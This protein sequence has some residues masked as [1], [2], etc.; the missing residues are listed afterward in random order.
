MKD[1]LHELIISVTSRCNLRCL[2]CGIPDGN[3]HDALSTAALKGLISDAVK[4]NPAS[5][6]F[7]GGEPLLREDIFE[8]ISFVNERKV[9]TCLTSNGSLINEDRAKLLAA[10]GV[11][12]VNISIEGPEEA[13]DLLRGRGNFEKAVTALENLKKHKI[14]TTIATVVCRHNYKSLAYV[15]GLARRYGVT[16]VK[17]QPF[18]GIFLKDEGTSRDFFAQEKDLKELD[19]AIEEVIKLSREYNISTNPESYLRKIPLYLCGLSGSNGKHGCSAL[20]SSCPI[21]ADGEV[22]PCWVLSAK[23]I[24]NI[25]GK[26]ISEIWNSK[27]HNRIRDLIAQDGCGGCLMSC[28]DYNFGYHNLVRMFSLKA[29]KLSRPKLYKRLYYRLYQQIRYLSG[30]LTKLLFN[31][32]RR[33]A[34]ERQEAIAEKLKEIRIAKEML[35]KSAESFKNE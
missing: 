8:L 28:Y 22:Y 16:T 15:L 9:N 7:S 17:F 4:L 19:R 33:R 20:W 32:R 21:S 29:H 13:H 26:K 1:R 24:G 27:E 2:M 30:K 25:T 35:R 10:S 6:V 5:I 14:E 18:S 23:P 31:K 12:V 34:G 3:A 11:G